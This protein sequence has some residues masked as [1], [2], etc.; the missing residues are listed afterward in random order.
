M[1]KF[2]NPKLSDYYEDGVNT[3]EYQV[4]TERGWVHCDNWGELQKELNEIK[5][6]FSN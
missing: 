5:E 4:Y 3:G 6:R 2:E 1:T